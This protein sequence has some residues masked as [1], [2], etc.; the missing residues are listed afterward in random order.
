[1]IVNRSIFGKIIR[2]ILILG[3]FVA[4]Y[5]CAK[6]IDKIKTQTIGIIHLSNDEA[7]YVEFDKNPNML[8]EDDTAIFKVH[9]HKC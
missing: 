6:T 7:M 4:G 1:M 8:K 5:Y 9:K 3:G 2:D